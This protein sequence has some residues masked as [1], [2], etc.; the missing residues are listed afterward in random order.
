MGSFDFAGSRYCVV[1]RRGLAQGNGGNLSYDVMTN[2]FFFSQ[3][4]SGR[5][6]RGKAVLIS[7]IE[8]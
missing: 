3:F 8:A 6:S 7:H 1:R 5:D 2:E 4:Y